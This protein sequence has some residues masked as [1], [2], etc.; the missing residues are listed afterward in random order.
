MSGTS[1][2][3][4]IVIGSKVNTRREA[5]V[6]DV[7]VRVQALDVIT[8]GAGGGSGFPAAAVKSKFQ[9][10]TCPMYSFLES[11]TVRVHS[12][13]MGTQEPICFVRL[14]AYTTD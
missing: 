11:L 6:G 5:R 9:L 1:T 8:V 2:D 10:L 3:V 14:Q 12:P 13:A 4:A 7:V